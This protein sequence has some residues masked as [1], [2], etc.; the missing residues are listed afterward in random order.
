[1][2]DLLR[3]LAE[4][5]KSRRP[6][7]YRDFVGGQNPAEISRNLGGQN[8]AANLAEITKSRRPKFCPE[9]RRDP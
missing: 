2:Y 6:K 9:S 4:I 7:S 1:M 8:P 3:D 5:P